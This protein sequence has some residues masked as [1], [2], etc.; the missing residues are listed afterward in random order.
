MQYGLNVTNFG[1][2]GD[3]LLLAELAH[4]AEQAGWDGFF[5]W[6]HIQFPGLEPTVDPWVALT[7]IAMRTERIKLGPM[8]T[9]LPRRHLGKL[10][11]EVLTL[12][13]LSGGRL[14]LGIG[15]GWPDLPEYTGFGDSGDAKVR[16]A[17][18]EEGLDVLRQ[19]LSGEPVEHNGEHYQITCG[20]FQAPAQE[21]I[22]IWLAATWPYKKPF[23]RAAKWDGV[24]PMH[25]DSMQGHIM[26]DEETRDLVAYVMEHR[27]DD[28]PY[29]IC[30]FGH[31]RDEND[32]E[33]VRTYADAGMTWWHDSVL[34]FMMS[35]DDV[36]ER[37]KR[38]PPRI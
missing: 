29:D 23:R 7:A 16:A 5:L 20:A 21:R 37:I 10:A 13:H 6:D 36:R 11:R 30:M 19:L 17:M 14:I 24:Y 32:T 2:C 1:Y 22:P 35:L 8:I 27:T 18:V 38:G 26:T 15:A 34:A 3:A 31:T 28:G 25:K 12:D 33:T 9:P 4:D